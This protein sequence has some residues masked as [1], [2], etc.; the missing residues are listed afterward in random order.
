MPAC[1]TLVGSRAK[2]ECAIKRVLLE[3]LPTGCPA[4]GTAISDS[5]KD[6]SWVN[7]GTALVRLADQAQSA[8]DR[9]LAERYIELAIQAFENAERVRAH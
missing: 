6:E 8:G 9:P 5:D 7:A 4:M 1:G 3:P 2:V